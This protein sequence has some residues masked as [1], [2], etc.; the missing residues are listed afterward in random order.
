M[1]SSAV[2]RACLLPFKSVPPSTRSTERAQPEL[3]DVSPNQ[4]SPPAPG[5]VYKSTKNCQDFYDS[6][7]IFLYFR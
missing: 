5:A 4:T 7:S 1:S 3:V 6:P 2:R